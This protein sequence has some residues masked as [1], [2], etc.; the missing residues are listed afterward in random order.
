ML[1]LM[2]VWAG[3]Y[4]VIAHLGI[5]ASF[6]RLAVSYLVSLIL[7]ALLFPPRYKQSGN[8]LIASAL[9]V[10]VVTLIKLNLDYLLIYLPPIIIPAGLLI[11]FLQS[12]QEEQIPV[13]TQFAMIIDGKSGHV[14]R[15]Y[16]R[17]ITQLWVG[18]FT[19]M[20]VEAIGLSIF[21]SIEIWS[22]ATHIGNYFL[23]AL[24][25]TL[26]FIYRKYRF[27]SNDIT[28]KKFILALVQY[29]WK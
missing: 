25:L 18:V 14:E 10:S 16:T 8:I 28:F 5:W 20:I 29:R 21:A 22:W 11:I 17:R 27:K 4:P 23:I 19:F 26:E 9:V 15:D 24:V 6:P 2:G 12:L 3:M 1:K 7:I 13:V